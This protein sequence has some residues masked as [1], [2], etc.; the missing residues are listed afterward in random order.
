M[1]KDRLSGLDSSFLHLERGPAHMHVASTTVFDG[2]PPHPEDLKEHVRSRLHLVPRFRQKLR[3]VPLGGGRP[4]WVDDPHFNLDYHVRTTALPAPGSDE[5]LRILAARVFS[6]RLDRSKPVWEMWLV[7]GLSDDRFAVVTKTHHCLVDGVSG[8][9]IT[10][11]LFDTAEDPEGSADPDPQ[12]VPDPEP[13]SAQ[14]L[15]DALLERATS[16]AEIARGVRRVFRAPRAAAKG[17]VDALEAAGTFAKAGLS[18]PASPFN[19]PIGPHRRFATVQARL[20]DFKRVKN[21]AGGTVNDV[22][23]AAV[24]GGVRRYLHRHGHD[25]DGL[26]LRALIPISVRADDQRGALGNRISAFQAPLPI[27]SEDPLE[28]LAAVS[29]TMGDLKSSKQAV[30]ATM[31]TELADF[32]PP[33]IAGQAARLQPGQRFFNMVVTNIPGPQFPLYLMGRRLRALFPMVPLARRQG[34]CF[35]IMSYDGEV[36]FGL[37]GDFDALADLDDLASDLADS[38][39]ELCAAVP[40]DQDAGAELSP[41]GSVNGAERHSSGPAGTPDRSGQS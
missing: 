27:W 13:S 10:T 6:Q 17:A 30:G 14:L 29:Q 39:R 19:V 16:P 4:V 40:A 2:P 3:F 20:A 7:E 26:E 25:T 5:Q 15:G 35:G 18:A 12:W 1:N 32:A 37:I 23:L 11:V 34:V 24:A 36:G 33:T 22:V 31:M 8:I 9:D 41:E 21:H 38:I 28:R